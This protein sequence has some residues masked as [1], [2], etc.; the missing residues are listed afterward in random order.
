[1]DR[2]AIALAVVGIVMAIY[3]W[4]SS[5]WNKEIAENY[6]EK[7]LNLL[8]AYNRL[9]TEYDRLYT[10]FTNITGK[11]QEAV[12]NLNESRVE[13][14]SLRN[15]IEAW[16]NN[17]TELE[18]RYLD[19][20]DF[21]ATSDKIRKY[22]SKREIKRFLE[23]DDTDEMEYKGTAWN[24]VDYSNLLIRHLLKEGLF[25]CSAVIRLEE[26][27]HAIVAFKTED[28]DLYYIEPQTDQIIP[29]DELRVGKDYC[30]VLGSDCEGWIIEKISSCFYISTYDE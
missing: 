25:A 11:Y 1:M 17:Y 8:E 18:E 3:F 26:G 19:L 27:D 6:K 9:C 15:T 20:L 5:E 10:N 4:Q 16:K 29:G 28:G 2:I 7:Y 30:K 13:I 21:V 24:C 12:A 23:E 14:E 22:A